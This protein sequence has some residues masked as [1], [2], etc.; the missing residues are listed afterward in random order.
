VV[1]GYSYRASFAADGTL[2]WALGL[3]GYS[4]VQYSAVDPS[5][6]LLVAG[7]I[8]GPTD[9]GFGT[10]SPQGPDAYAARYDPGSGAATSVVPITDSNQAHGF[11]APG[12]IASD[13]SGN[14]VVGGTFTGQIDLGAGAMTAAK[15]LAGPDVFVALIER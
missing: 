10:I 2:R 11:Q 12:G 1:D 15:G 4:G 5:G 8:Q 6:E 7:N 9:F 13:A 3:S 14:W